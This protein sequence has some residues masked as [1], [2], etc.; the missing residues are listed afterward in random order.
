MIIE[1]LLIFATFVA[2]TLTMGAV[3]PVTGRYLSR[4]STPPLYTAFRTTEP[5]SIDGRL[6]EADWSAASVTSRFVDILGGESGVVP[7][8]V[9]VRMM[10]DDDNLYIGARLSE[11]N[12]I[13]NLTQRD[14]IIYH[15]NDFE[16]FLDPDGDGRNYFEFET[17]ARG[18]LMD[19]MLNKPYRSGG[20][21][22]LPWNCAGLRLAI[23]HDGTL[24]DSS[25]TDT[26]WSVEMAVPFDALKLNFDDPRQYR[27]WRVNF[28]R[29]QWPGGGQPEQNWVWAPTGVV[30]IHIPERWGFVQ[31]DNRPVG[32]TPEP[33]SLPLDMDA[34]RLLWSLFY[35]Q[36]DNKAAKGTYLR[37]VEDCSLDSVS[38]K[39]VSLD[40]GDSFF[41]LSVTVPERGE[42]YTLDQ[43]GCFSHRPVQPRTV[44]NWV[45]TG[46]ES[47]R[48]SGQWSEWFDALYDAGISA[49]LFEGYDEELYR[50]CHDAG[51]EAHYWKWTLNR[52]DLLD[53]HPDWYAVNRIGES[54]WDK[55]AYVDYYRFL[56]PSRSSVSTF[57]ASDY[58]EAA[59]QPYVDGMHLDYIRVP[60]VVLPVSLW[61]KYGIEQTSEHAEYDYCYCD[62][63]RE[64]FK[65]LTGRDPLDTEYPMEDQSWINFRL[66]AVTGIVK[67]I[68]DTLHAHNQYLSSAVFPGPSMARKMVRQDWGNWNLDAYFPMI[69]NG[70]YNEGPEWIGRSVRE[71]VDAL[72]GRAPLYC[73]LMCPDLEG[74]DF[75]KALD[76]AFDNGAAGISFFAGPD[77]L[78][79]SALRQYLESHNMR[80]SRKH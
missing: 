11:D 47:E 28:S 59:R 31:F 64:S 51:L 80:P 38:M 22:F 35:L 21:F 69:Y 76:E 7:K 39:S 37:R 20:S 71:G 65:R 75:V 74:D 79:M 18:V 5:I 58:L 33:Y 73:G 24:N 17:N 8:G 49:V 23:S 29:V 19:L 72:G 32:S 26:A 53:D 54:S 2:G 14:T 34:Y 1:R 62:S 67:A 55:P 57:L 63:C 6:D 13:A 3:A 60:D 42:I 15:D 52:R 27:V 36:A 25:D 68:A 44:K 4:M 40:A 78:Q 16:V 48:T 46:I 43:S 61:S 9:E 77:T 56:C 10:W 70:F 66:D 30:D 41:E 50:L 12:I 45:W